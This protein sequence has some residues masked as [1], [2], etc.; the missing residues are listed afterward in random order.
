DVYPNPSRDIFNVTFTSEEAQ[1]I[2]VK[3]VNMIGE[4][5]YTEELTD[6]VGQCTKVV[7]MN[8]QP[9]GVYFLE[10]TANNGVV[11]HKIILQ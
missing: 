4:A 6:F 7:D 2:S 10:I 5:I 8:T 9:K 1:T 11:N 3:V